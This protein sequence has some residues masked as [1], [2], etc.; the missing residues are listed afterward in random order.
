MRAIRRLSIASLA[1]IAA[2]TVAALTVA[3]IGTPQ[4]APSLS[5]PGRLVDLGGYRFHLLCLGSRAPGRPLVVFSPG[6]GDFATD[7]LPV[8]E[9][10][11]D[12]L[13]VCSYD[14][15]AFGWSEP[16]PHP[17]TFRQEAFEL[18]LALERAGERGPY[19][20]VGHS[21]GAC[22]AREFARAYRPDVAGMVLIE[23]ANEN[24]MLGYRGQWVLPRTLASQRPI[25]APRRYADAPP[26][27]DT[28]VDGD[29][30]RARALRTAR[31]WRPYDRLGAAAQRYRVWALG[32]PP[33]VVWQ[34]DLFA[35]EMAGFY[36][37]WSR[38][39]HPLADLPLTVIRGGPRPPPP[40][41][42]DAQ[43]RADSARVDLT[44]LSSRGRA[45]TDSLSGHHVQL[46][47]PRLVVR[48][49]RD[50][51]AGIR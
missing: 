29:S 27:R 48:A 24:G 47:N 28:T 35:E 13:R 32:H 40:G 23:P 4:D 43:V 37:E 38:S 20:L 19:V 16:G 17:H 31:I 26:V 51:V 11:S 42:T 1:I 45:I 15:P 30:C 49:V 50:L 33:C 44:R 12:S 36:G 6:G 39:P 21:L 9:A 41:L 7:W 14:R 34:D 8:L 2:L 3:A 25:P 22:V 46:D 10:L 18:H 5:A